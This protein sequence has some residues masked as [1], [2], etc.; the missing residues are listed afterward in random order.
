MEKGRIEAFTDGVIAVIITIMVLELKTPHEATLHALLANW[1][2]FLSYVL[3]FIYVAIYWNNHH[4]MMHVVK[5]I[6]GKVMWANLHVLFWLS[7]FPFMTSWL[8]E[9]EPRPAAVPSALYG[10]VLLMAAVAWVLL[11]RALVE[12]NGGERSTLARAIGSD[13]KSRLSVLLYLAAIGLA[14]IEPVAS[15]GLYLV[16]ATLWLIPDPRIEARVVDNKAGSK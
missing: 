5:H 8:S 15:C 12:C 7:L 11:V 4:H 2:I 13:W 6:N 14:F 10:T 9:T 16:V 1:P 3:S